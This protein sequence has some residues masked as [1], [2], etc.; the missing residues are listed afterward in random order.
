MKIIK[1]ILKTI[2]SLVIGFGIGMLIASL[3]FDFQEKEL[4]KVFKEYKE[5]KKNIRFTDNGNCLQT[6]GL[7]GFTHNFK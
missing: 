2:L 6:D 5:Y 7:R 4:V 1:N 3:W